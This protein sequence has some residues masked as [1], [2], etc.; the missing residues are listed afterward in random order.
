M[1]QYPIDLTDTEDL[2]LAYVALS[3]EDWIENVVRDR[4]R[5]AG[6]EIVKIS[7]EKCLE[8]GNQIPATR[9][10]IIQLAFNKGWVQTVA[11]RNAEQPPLISEG[12]L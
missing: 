6:D 1:K 3:Q 11:Q 9:D 2:C 4:C 10:D 7:V 8:T 12:T 5:I